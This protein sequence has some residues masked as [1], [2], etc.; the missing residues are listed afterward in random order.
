[1]PYS[2]IYFDLDDTLLDHM[3]A[4]EHALKDVHQHFDYLDGIRFDRLRETYHAINKFLW[5][6]YSAQNIT[7]EE[8][9]RFRFERTLYRLLGDG[10]KFE[11][12]GDFYLNHYANY[13]TWMPGA[14]EIYNWT[15]EHYEV[16]ILTNGF[17]EQQDLKFK[18]FDLYSSA[19]ALLISEEVQSMKPHPAVFEEATKRAG[20]PASEILYV[21]DSYTSDVIGGTEFGWDVVWLTDSDD[22]E[23][24]ALATHTIN[25]LDELKNILS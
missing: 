25:H 3:H 23:K 5:E 15:L 14:K 8:L 19:K 18:K 1:L 16:G 7:K 12:V 6:E 24:R 20:V 9:Q 11:E 17:L 13:W 22:K 2:F 21:G 4:E 10:G